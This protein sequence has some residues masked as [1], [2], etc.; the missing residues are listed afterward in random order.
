MH[1]AGVGGTHAD[2]NAAKEFYVKNGMPLE[3]LSPHR[4]ADFILMISE[5]FGQSVD[6]LCDSFTEALETASIDA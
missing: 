1:V 3:G 6:D 5:K 4:F 2:I